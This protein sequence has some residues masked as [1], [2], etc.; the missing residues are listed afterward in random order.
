[1]DRISSLLDELADRRI[2]LKLTGDHLEVQAPRGSLTADLRERLAG[3]K[4]EIVAWLARS[5]GGSQAADG[6]LPTVEHD[7]ERLYEPF[8]PSDLQQSFLMGSREGFEF[9]VRPHQYGEFDFDELDAGRFQ[10]AFHRAV[11]RQRKNLVVADEDMLLRTVRDPAPVEF[12]VSDLRGLPADE[13]ERAMLALREQMERQE[14]AHCQ[15]PWLTPH[16]SLYGERGAR[17]HYNNNNLFA[18]APSAFR[19]LSDALHYYHHPDDELPEL[20]VAFRD[21]VLT[22]AELEASPLGERSKKY[23]CD[24][25]ADWPSAPKLPLVS[26][27]VRRRR[28]EL[29]RRELLLEPRI[30]EALQAR[31]DARGLT[32]TNVL[33]GAHAEVIAQWS[34][35]RHFLLNNMITHRLP[36]HPQM[37][38]IL[39][40]FAS[41]YPLEVD[42]RQPEGFEE[43]VRRLQARVMSDT[44]HTYWSGSKVLQTLNQVRQTPGSAVCPFAV[45]SALFVGPADPPGYSLLETPQTLLDTEFWELRDGRL[46]VIWDAIE[47]MFP[48]GM[49]EEMLAAYGLLVTRL[50]EDESAWRERDFDLLPAAQRE[51]RAAINEEAL[52]A[53]GEPPVRLLHEVLPRTAAAQ[54]D[55]PAVIGPDAK[56][57]YGEL[58]E[59]SLQIAARLGDCGA[60]AGHVVAVA[61]SKSPEQIAAV[62]GVLATGA[63]YV[64]VDPEWPTDRIRYVLADTSAVAVVTSAA[65][66]DRLAEAASVPLVTVEECA[67][68]R[69]APDAHPGAATRRPDDLAYI[70]YT[71]GS[72]G[73]PKGAMLDHGG[74]L[75]TVADINRR[76]G[77][78][79]SDVLFGVSSLCFDLSVYD[80]FGAAAAGASLVLPAASQTDPASWIDTVRSFGVTVWNSVP[81]LMQL[82]VEEA[83]AAGVRL[84]SL[85]TVLLSGDW[86]PVDLPGRIREVAPNARVISLGGATEAS[87]WSI[88]HPVDAPDP[89][90]ASVPYGRPLAGQSWHVLDGSGRD[91][92]VWVPGDLY[93]GGRGLALGY[94]NDPE[95]TEA[96]FVRHPRTGERMYRTGDQGR[97]LPDGTIEFLG[98]SDF[99]VKIQG[100][101]VELGE[102]EHALLSCPGVGKAVVVAPDAASGRQLVAFVVRDRR[103]DVSEVS[104]TAWVAK[105]TAQ[106]GRLVPHYMVP[107]RIALLDALP[108]TGNGKLDR[109]ALES[110]SRPEAGQDRERTA[111]RNPLE[112]LL[113]EIWESVLGVHPI[114][115]H[116]D[117][118]DLG[119]QSFAALRVLRQVTGRTGNRVPLGLLLE[120]RTIAELAESLQT[121]QGAW[122]ALVTLRGR[123]RAARGEPLFL[124]HPAG[125]NVAC[126]RQLAELLDRPVYAF[127]APGPSTGHEPLSTVDSLARL[128][129]DALRDVQPCGPYLLG[130]WSSGGVIA[131]EAAR[132][133]EEQGEAVERVVVLDSPAPSLTRDVDD[134]Q[135]LVWFLEDLGIGFKPGHAPLDE[136]RRLDGMRDVDRIA[137]AL[138]IGCANGLPDTGLDAGDLVSPLAVFRGVVRACNSYRGGVIDAPIDVLR[139]DQGVVSEFAGHPHTA[140]SDWGWSGFSR[141]GASAMAIPGT[142]YTLLADPTAVTAVTHAIDQLGAPSITRSTSVPAHQTTKEN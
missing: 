58:R 39:G 10:E 63:A 56:V 80:V 83:V 95:K 85:R 116:D 128:Y 78:T 141:A 5:A 117:F 120:R 91:A 55:A 97:Y 122:T 44:E 3:H 76:F 42:W 135:L 24:R 115:V 136:V 40:N 73:R 75:N 102:I 21:C 53:A 134:A 31:A 96:S 60:G 26:S 93:I 25:M 99:Q 94:W 49:I 107:G 28:S 46:W 100:F 23:W 52:G 121:A 37:R 133:L 74:P 17:F 89:A 110:L 68:R 113:T 45:G 109:R 13:A 33:L 32:L 71:S 19:L 15:W 47:P 105:L 140:A 98:R 51:Q 7:A 87:I 106:L 124:M 70:I 1:M 35:S 138:A 34:G 29:S 118:F 108:L 36:L 22:L 132:L 112:A 4:Q 50:A 123:E 11:H 65:L 114:G 59:R 137:R 126:Y 9:Y 111:A 88:C 8:A 30:R 119:G 69:E 127:Q 57:S 12:T 84:P 72:T 61:L 125:G 6:E 86:I 104:G 79:S 103:A 38:E 81:A 66:R 62:H 2:K 139:A 18:D 82:F 101:R 64:P 48:A 27:A 130:G 77:V 20:E 92:P 129:V 43:R 54:P 16:L 90:W 131:F 41:L 14:P 67:R 142:H